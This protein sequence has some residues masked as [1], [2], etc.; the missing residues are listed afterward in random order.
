MVRQVPPGHIATYGDIATLVGSPRRARHVGFAL[1]AL[2]EDDV[3][4]HRIINAQGTISIRGDT[5]RGR[6]QRELLESEGII[7]DQRAR[8]DLARFRWVPTSFRPT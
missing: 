3:P 5:L 6:L 4:W 1:S 8:V 2:R 7:F